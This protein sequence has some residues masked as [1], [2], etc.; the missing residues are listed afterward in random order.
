MDNKLLWLLIPCI[1]LLALGLMFEMA[2]IYG[3]KD[4]EFT[5]KTEMDNNTLK[6]IMLNCQV[7]CCNMKGISSIDNHTYYDINT[8]CYNA[9]L[10]DIIE[11]SQ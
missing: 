5:I 10:K 4:F 3:S 11:V 7:Q 1:T 8:T 6:A 9:C 2:W